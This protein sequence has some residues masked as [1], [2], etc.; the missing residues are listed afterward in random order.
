MTFT[1]PADFEL[2]KKECRKWID[3]LSLNDW[4]YHYYHTDFTNTDLEDSN[5]T[6]TLYPVARA[7]VLRLSK[8]LN[9]FEEPKRETIK[10]C[11]LHEVLHVLQAEVS[12]LASNR[13]YNQ[14]RYNDVEHAVIH[15]LQKAFKEMK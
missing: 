6:V 11:A 10:E 8:T 5:S 15:R 7:A 13:D 4:E 2:F 3:I 9:T 12:A 1:T 14:K